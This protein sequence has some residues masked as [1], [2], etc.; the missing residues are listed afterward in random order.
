M[1]CG[2][3]TG[4]KLNDT[5][6]RIRLRKEDDMARN[7]NG[8]G[9]GTSLLVVVAIGLAIG[10]LCA[11]RSGSETR[12]EIREKISDTKA[13]AERI[14]AEAKETATRIIDDAKRRAADK[15]EV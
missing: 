6:R 9:F 11:P 10:L 8:H 14:L 13:R 5:N 15:Q 4:R 2:R 12:A 3:A 1:R 7:E